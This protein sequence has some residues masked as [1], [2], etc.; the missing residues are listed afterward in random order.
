[1]APACAPHQHRLPGRAG[2]RA[3]RHRR[4]AEGPLQGARRGG[5]HELESEDGPVRLDLG[6]VVYVRA[7]SEELRVGFGAVAAVGARSTSGCCG[8]R[9]PAGTAPAAE[10]AVARFSRLGRARRR[11][12]CDRARS[13]R[14][15]DRPRRARWRRAT[16]DGGGRLRANTASSCSSAAPPAASGPAAADAHADA[17]E[18]PQRPRLDL[19]RRRARYSRL[20]LPAAPLYA[21]AVC[22]APARG[23]TWACTTPPTSSRARCSAARRSR[24][25]RPRDRRPL[26]SRSGLDPQP[27]GRSR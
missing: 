10:R 13:G 24:L 11:V 7:E 8:W 16:G 18:L 14:L 23:C 22:L 4:A 12:A 5:W 6:Q 15:L 26:R 27:R 21:L 3:A 1:M 2:A 25:A 19:V 17:A 20:G 9:A